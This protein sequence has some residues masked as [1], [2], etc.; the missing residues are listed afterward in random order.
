MR[1]AAPRLGADAEG[2]PDQDRQGSNRASP[3]F[4]IVDMERETQAA[5]SWRR[6]FGTVSTLTV[7]RSLEEDTMNAS[8]FGWKA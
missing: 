4:D 8:G 6:F 1:G 7:M 2:V 3:I 5:A